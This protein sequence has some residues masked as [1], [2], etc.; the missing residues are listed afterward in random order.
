MA[1]QKYTNSVGLQCRPTRGRPERGWDKIWRLL[2]QQRYCVFG[3][4]WW[5]T[6]LLKVERLASICRARMS[7]SSIRLK[8]TSW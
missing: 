7:G 1:I 5:G 4:M 2:L 6:V 8:T 3:T